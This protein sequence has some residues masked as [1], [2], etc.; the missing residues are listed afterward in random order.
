MG[1]RALWAGADEPRQGK[2]TPVFLSVLI[3]LRGTHCIFR[4][5]ENMTL[6][7]AAVNLFTGGSVSST[8]DLDSDTHK[9][10]FV[11]PRRM[12]A[13]APAL[14]AST[15]LHRQERKE[16]SQIKVENRAPSLGC[17]CRHCSRPLGKK[18]QDLRGTRKPVE[19]GEL[20]KSHGVFRAE[21]S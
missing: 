3:T 17:S 20:F 6:L 14:A 8:S 12:V 21:G 11:D 5:E 15:I 2:Q 4:T 18:K 10:A 13:S 1:L 19:P 16:E 9:P 7:K